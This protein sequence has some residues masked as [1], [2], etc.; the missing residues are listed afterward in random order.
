[1]WYWQLFSEY[2]SFLWFVPVVQLWGQFTFVVLVVN[3]S[4]SHWEAI[5][6]QIVCVQDSLAPIAIRW[7]LL[8][9][10]H[11]LKLLGNLVNFYLWYVC[12]VFVSKVYIMILDV[13][14]CAILIASPL[15]LTPFNWSSLKLTMSKVIKKLPVHLLLFMKSALLLKSSN[16]WSDISTDCQPDIWIKFFFRLFL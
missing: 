3:W 8:L 15:L 11:L 2:Q 9:Q 5:L 6:E 4:F 13:C 1:M 14:F 7:S 12:S 10:S 16:L